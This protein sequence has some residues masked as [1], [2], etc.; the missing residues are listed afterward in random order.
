M[1]QIVTRFVVL[2]L[3]VFACNLSLGQGF[4]NRPIR[5]VVPAGQGG[6]PDTICRV[7]A[8]RMTESLGQPVIIE[9]RP[10]AGGIQGIEAA[11]TAPADGYTLLQTDAGPLAINPHLYAKLSY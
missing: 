2:A 9:N 10:S 11:L 7:I 3:S 8:Q 4:P 6:M 1:K 5:L